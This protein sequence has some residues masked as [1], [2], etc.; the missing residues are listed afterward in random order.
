M[1]AALLEMLILI[2]LL[3][4]AALWCFWINIDTEMWEKAVRKWLHTTW[5]TVACVCLIYWCDGS[6][7][8]WKWCR[9]DPVKVNRLCILTEKPTRS[10]AITLRGRSA[11]LKIAL[12]GLFFI[13]CILSVPFSSIH[14]SII[15]HL[16]VFLYLSE[17]SL[18]IITAA[19]NLCNKCINVLSEGLFYSSLIYIIF[20]T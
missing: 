14:C 17:K 1:R 9:I 4:D 20:K 19:W 18:Q 10:V 5:S 12:H 8:T 11:C 7:H 3:C 13:S 16:F 6:A 15:Y 2:L